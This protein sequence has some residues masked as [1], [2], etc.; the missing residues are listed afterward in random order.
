MTKPI[1]VSN[2][3][4]TIMIICYR[5]KLEIHRI[6]Y[7]KNSVEKYTLIYEFV[8]QKNIMSV[9]FHPITNSIL[10]IGFESGCVNL[11]KLSPDEISPDRLLSRIA[12]LDGHKNDVLSLTFNPD[13]SILAS[14]SKDETVILFEITYDGDILTATHAITIVDIRKGAYSL[15]YNEDGS[16]LAIGAGNNEVIFKQFTKSKYS[17]SISNFSGCINCI[18]FLRILG[19]FAVSS[20]SIVSIFSQTESG[21]LYSKLVFKINIGFH[22]SSI[23]Y[24]PISNLLMIGCSNGIKLF[25]ISYDSSSEKLNA[26]SKMN[27]TGLSN[28]NAVSFHPSEEILIISSISGVSFWRHDASLTCVANIENNRKWW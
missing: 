9:N 16:I 27:I 15:A 7:I 1:F 18:C 11:F 6:S 24:D 21:S 19:F 10:A 8:F 13:G 14:G 28:V 4:M 12:T 2:K 20:G 25:H 5:K 23:C 17:S 22:V 3:D 26:V